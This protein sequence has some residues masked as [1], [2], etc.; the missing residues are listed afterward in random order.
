MA[1]SAHLDD[2]LKQV[3]DEERGSGRRP[4]GR[5]RGAGRSGPPGGKLRHIHGATLHEPTAASPRKDYGP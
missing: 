5:R 1:R 4:A 3:V 2:L